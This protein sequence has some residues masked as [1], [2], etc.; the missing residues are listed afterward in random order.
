MPLEDL[1][2]NPDSGKQHPVDPA[3]VIQAG[4][5]LLLCAFHTDSTLKAVI[6]ALRRVEEKHF[7]PGISC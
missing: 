2:I 5:L 7:L 3:S 6:S 4:K 1:S